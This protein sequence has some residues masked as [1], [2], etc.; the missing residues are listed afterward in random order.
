[1]ER[2][3]IGLPGSFQFS[4]TITVR[5]TDL[6]YGGHVGNDSFLS[7]I[8]EARV[9]F[10]QSHGYS[11]LDLEGNGLIMSDM[12]IEF[13]KE[14]HYGDEVLVS[15]SAAGFAPYGFDLFYLLEIV[16]AGEKVLSAKAKTG[17][18]CYNY[19][20]KKLALL[21]PEALTKLSASNMNT[22]T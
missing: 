2:I 22:T 16:K 5:I 6:N 3:S 11:E 15:V 4:T 20:L 19:R 10:L 9:R 7:L 8:H 14:L 17:M 12:G 21:P 13:K 18:L 1:M